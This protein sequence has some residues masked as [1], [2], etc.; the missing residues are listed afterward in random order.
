MSEEK[1]EFLTNNGTL[2]DVLKIALP[3]I[4]SSSCHAVNMFMDR[5]MLTRYSQARAAAALT[6]GL[7]SFTLQCFFV[8]AVGYAGTFVAQYSG[9]NQ[10]QR[11][12][13][14]VWQ[15]IFMAIAG[16]IFMASCC[17]WIPH[18][19]AALGHEAEVE[20]QENT[21]FKWL[22]LGCI[23]FLLQQALSCF[24]SGRGKTTMV[25]AVS[26]WV[27]VLNLPLN[28]AFIYG[29]WGCPEM[30]TAGAALG[31]ILAA[32]GGLLVYAVGFFGLKK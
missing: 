17:L 13:T 14:A 29:K 23:V 28:Y 31:T 18:L 2:V 25:L 30:G 5:L 32:L 3:L 16:A 4:L 12:G 10:P 22:A 24:W 26:I 9:A 27:T 11:V 8:G 20:V 6:G 7:T 19:F 21:Y 1:S 15:G